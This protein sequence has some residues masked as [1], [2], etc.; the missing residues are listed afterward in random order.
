MITTVAKP[1]SRCRLACRSEPLSAGRETGSSYSISHLQIAQASRCI[2][3]HCRHGDWGRSWSQ[4]LSSSHS[5]W[6]EDLKLKF[7][8][9][10]CSSNA[11]VRCL[12][13]LLLQADLEYQKAIHDLCRFEQGIFPS[14]VMNAERHTVTWV[15]SRWS[16]TRISSGEFCLFRQNINILFFWYAHRRKVLF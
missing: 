8:K 13:P 16:P 14:Q 4:T 6:G 1:Q 3:R 9:S 11:S 5:V 2:A 10:Q 7:I 15:A 12:L